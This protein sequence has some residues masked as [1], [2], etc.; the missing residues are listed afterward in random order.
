MVTSIL[1]TSL[2]KDDRVSLVEVLRRR[3]RYQTNQRAYTFLIEGETPDSESTLN[4]TAL[5]KITLP[6]KNV[7]H[8]TY[9]ELDRQAKAIASAPP[10]RA[11][12]STTRAEA[13]GSLALI[14]KRKK[15]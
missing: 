9:G 10:F 14:P 1:R 12:P 11:A 15:P 3:D 7:V 4:E 6:Q 8:I 2:T 5:S 13:T